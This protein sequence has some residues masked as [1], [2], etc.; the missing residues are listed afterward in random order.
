MAKKKLFNQ[1]IFWGADNLDYFS[2]LR[3]GHFHTRHNTVWTELNKATDRLVVGMPPMLGKDIKDYFNNVTKN[4]PG[5]GTRGAQDEGRANAGRHISALVRL[6]V[7]KPV[8]Q[9]GKPVKIY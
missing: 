5:T 9:N 1:N 7:L 4:Y 3:E 8:V 2:A 6:G